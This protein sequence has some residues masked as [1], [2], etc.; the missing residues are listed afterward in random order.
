MRRYP[1]GECVVTAGFGNPRALTEAEVAAHKASRVMRPITYTIAL[2]P[3]V[4]YVLHPRPGAAWSTGYVFTGEAETLAASEDV[5]AL[6]AAA[7]LLSGSAL[8]SGGAGH[9]PDY[10][11]DWGDVPVGE[12]LRGA[13][14]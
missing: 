3:R 6:Y 8:R 5:D 12:L 4:F 14:T 7:W 2:P 1:A 9:F 10:L 11:A 13:H